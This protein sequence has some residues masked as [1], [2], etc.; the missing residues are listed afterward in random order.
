MSSPSLAEPVPAQ[1]NVASQRLQIPLFRQSWPSRD[2]IPLIPSLISGPATEHTQLHPY[3]LSEMEKNLEKTLDPNNTYYKDS[4][5][6]S[7]TASKAPRSPSSSTTCDRPNFAPTKI[8]ENI[9]DKLRAGRLSQP[10]DAVP[11][12]NAPPP[13]S[14][15]VNDGIDPDEFCTRL[16]GIP[17]AI[18]WMRH[19]GPDNWLFKRLCPIRIVNLLLHVFHWRDK[20]YVDR[21][22]SF[23]S[24]ASPAIF[25]RFADLI[26]CLAYK[27][28][29]LGITAVICHYVDD[30]Y[31]IIKSSFEDA[32]IVF[33]GFLALPPEAVAFSVEFTV[34]QSKVMVGEALREQERLEAN[35]MVIAQAV[36]ANNAFTAHAFEMEAYRQEW[37]KDQYDDYDLHSII[38]VLQNTVPEEHKGS[39]QY[40][41][42]KKKAKGDVMQNGVLHHAWLKRKSLRN[43]WGQFI[44]GEQYSVVSQKSDKIPV[45]M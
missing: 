1:F 2:D 15:S 11:H 42:A 20:F 35:A 43:L 7:R 17:T 26:A 32:Q 21:N 41:E 8:N 40:I 4:E 23:R 24:R 27:R 9:A 19:F 3:V 36:S 45:Q 39:R 29:P 34:Q 33:R 5:A 37:A 22:A 13:G 44:I 31:G 12:P 25:N 30:F 38:N 10:L 6:V 14:I 18:A 28:I 16:E